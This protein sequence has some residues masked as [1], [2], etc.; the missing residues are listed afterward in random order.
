MWG[1]SHALL[2][3]MQREATVSWRDGHE[4][5]TAGDEVRGEPGAGASQLR[6]SP[7]RMPPDHGALSLG[8]LTSAAGG[9]KRWK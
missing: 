1:G 3:H 7:T 4:G 6:M 2:R 5:P 9:L 8:T